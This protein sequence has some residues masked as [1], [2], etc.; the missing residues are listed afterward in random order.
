MKV[1]LPFQAMNQYAEDIPEAFRSSACG[2]VTA[3]SILHYHEGQAPGIAQLYKQLGATVIGLSALCLIRRM[4]KLT[5]PRYEIKRVR[6]IEQVKQ[7]LIAGHPL[8]LK[9]D[10]YFSFHWREKT[11]FAYH[12]VVLVGFEETDEDVT[13]F[14][15]DNGQ[16]NRP[17]KLRAVSL[18]ENRNVLS[19]IRITPVAKKIT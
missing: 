18:R 15:H 5:G 12:W 16:K 3:A 7:E 2:P 19:F 4:Q 10:R 6:S 8:A 14:V 9:F 11:A 17:S 1:L 13:L